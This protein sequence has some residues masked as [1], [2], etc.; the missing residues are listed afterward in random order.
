M[1]KSTQLH[2]AELES[3]SE[4]LVSPESQSRFCAPTPQSC[5]ELGSKCALVENFRVS[6]TSLEIDLYNPKKYFCSKLRQ[7]FQLLLYV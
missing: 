1:S 6:G 7:L 3:E 4:E 2:K 5:S